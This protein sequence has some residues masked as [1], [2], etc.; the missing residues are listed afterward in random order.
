MKKWFVP[1]IITVSILLII[2]ALISYGIYWA[3]FDIQRLDGQEVMIA[4]ESPDSLYTVTAYL[5]NGG[6]TTDYAVLCAVKNNKTGKNRNIYWNYHCSTADI[7][8]L[9]NKT[10]I[11]NGIELDVTKDKYD[12]RKN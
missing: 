6:A 1:V 8:W 7:Q 4:S 9:D 2:F 3:F 11:I 12:Y 5:N 10:V